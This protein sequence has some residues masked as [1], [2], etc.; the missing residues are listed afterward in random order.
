MEPVKHFAFSILNLSPKLKRE[1][2]ISL[3]REDGIFLMTANK[4]TKLPVLK[5]I[6]STPN[7]RMIF[8]FLKKKK[9]T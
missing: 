7:S 6:P 8:R 9:V 4:M 3:P 5:W 2:E 1:Q